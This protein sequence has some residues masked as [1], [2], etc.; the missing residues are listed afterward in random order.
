MPNNPNELFVFLFLLNMFQNQ[1][2]SLL[3]KEKLD[4]E[5]SNKGL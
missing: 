2:T 1:P 5:N 3:Q 4:N